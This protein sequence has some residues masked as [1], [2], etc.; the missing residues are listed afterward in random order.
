[1]TIEITKPEIY[2]R[3]IH[4]VDFE[5]WTKFPDSF[6]GV[7]RIEFQS[8]HTNEYSG[9]FRKKDFGCYGFHIIF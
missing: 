5:I 4:S 1:M 9:L 8:G 2:Q 7:V 3:R 6:E